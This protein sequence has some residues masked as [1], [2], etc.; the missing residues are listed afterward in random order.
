MIRTILEA[1]NG[2]YGPIAILALYINI[3]FVIHKTLD[4]TNRI[5]ALEKKGNK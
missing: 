3:V 2:D 4:N 5:E 1:L